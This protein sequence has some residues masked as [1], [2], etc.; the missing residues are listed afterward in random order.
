MELA[1]ISARFPSGSEPGDLLSS[2]ILRLPDESIKNIIFT[3]V[4]VSLLIQAAKASKALSALAGLIGNI[5][6]LKKDKVK[7]FAKNFLLIN[8]MTFDIDI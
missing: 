8:L 4:E 6:V 2:A 7:A 3:C 1:I 5:R